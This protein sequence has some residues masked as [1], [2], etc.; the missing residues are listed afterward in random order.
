METY[1]FEGLRYTKEQMLSM[2]D[3]SSGLYEYSKKIERM[4]KMQENNPIFRENDLV[5]TRYCRRVNRI[6]LQEY[7]PDNSPDILAP[8]LYEIRHNSNGDVWLEVLGGKFEFQEQLF[9]I[10][11]FNDH[12]IKYY[13]EYKKTTAVIFHG[14]PGTGKTI[15]AKLLANQLNLPIILVNDY[16]IM[17]F[18]LLDKI[19]QE[20]IVFFDEFEKTIGKYA[21][22]AEFL[23]WFDGVSKSSVP[24]ISILT[25]N[26]LSLSDKYTGR[27]GRIRY[28]KEFDG[29]DPGLIDDI[30]EYYLKDSSNKEFILSHID[31]KTLTID[32][33]RALINEVNIFGPT[34]ESIKYLNI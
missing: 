17:H 1:K 4:R 14:K 24:K 20:V 11:D 12:F 16:S 10:D 29:I 27:P 9:K 5:S 32:K 3:Q 18:D 6:Y 30:L 13:D 8:G 25:V 28:I 33:L 2:M 22:N 31:L 19:H 26:D 21:D 7:E 34:E 23:S 15:Q